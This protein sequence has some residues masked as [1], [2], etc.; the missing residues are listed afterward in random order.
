M[1]FNKPMWWKPRRSRFLGLGHVI[2]RNCSNLSFQGHAFHPI[3]T[4]ARGRR[5]V[6]TESKDCF[7][8]QSLGLYFFIPQKQLDACNPEMEGTSACTAVRP[9]WACYVFAEM[10]PFES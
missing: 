6:P 4:M 5:C 1:L 10:L 8:I 2:L 7:L 9:R 3:F